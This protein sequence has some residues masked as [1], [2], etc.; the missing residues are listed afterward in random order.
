M[1]DG[2]GRDHSTVTS[3]RRIGLARALSK[4]GY[5]SRSQAFTLIRAGRVRVNNAITRDPEGYIV[6]DMRRIFREE[7]GEWVN[8]ESFVAL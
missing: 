3:T 4:L 8:P 2:L 7:L 5:C 6:V 1:V